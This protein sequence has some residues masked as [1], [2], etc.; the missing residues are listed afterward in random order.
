MLARMSE[1]DTV[2]EARVQ[3]AFLMLSELENPNI[4]VI[5]SEN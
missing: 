1:N 4:A 5:V 3:A 2:I